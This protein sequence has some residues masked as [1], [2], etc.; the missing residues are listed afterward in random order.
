MNCSSCASVPTQKKLDFF[1]ATILLIGFFWSNDSFTLVKRLII[2]VEKMGL[3][4]K[5]SDDKGIDMQKKH[6]IFLK[7]IHFGE[8]N[9][10]FL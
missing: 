8:K 1:G 7:F 6:G 10:G 4:A 2:N 5:M 3:A 9:L